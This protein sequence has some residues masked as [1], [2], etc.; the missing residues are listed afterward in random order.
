[1]NKDDAELLLEKERLKKEKI[2]K[3]M[4]EYRTNNEFRKKNADY[5]KEYRDKQKKLLE[6]A[7]KIINNELKD[8]DKDKD[9]DKKKTKS[10]KTIKKYISIILK[11]H[12]LINKTVE[13]DSKLLSKLFIEKID[14]NEENILQNQLYYL[15]DINKFIEIMKNKYTNIL[16]LRDNINPYLIIL[17]KIQLFKVNYTK[18]NKFYSE[19]KK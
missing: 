2:R 5:M 16:T 9:K 4:H 1:M 11:N 12:K 6:D 19:L 18:L 14:N 10:E 7:N 17:Q 15:K 3:R 8:K 13:L